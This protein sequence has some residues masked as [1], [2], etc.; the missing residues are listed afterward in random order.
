MLYLSQFEKAEIVTLAIKISKKNTFSAS[1]ALSVL[2][3]LINKGYSIDELDKVF[4]DGID[5]FEKC[6]V[7]F[8]LTADA[9]IKK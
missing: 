2:I 8:G 1:E 7:L 3:S 6:L 4:G 9:N 5:V